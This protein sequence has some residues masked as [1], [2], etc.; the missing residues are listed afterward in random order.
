VTPSDLGRLDLGRLQ[1]TDL[2]GSQGPIMGAIPG[3][4]A[5][6]EAPAQ[7]ELRPTC[8]G[9]SLPGGATLS[10]L[11]RMI[12]RA[13]SRPT[14]AVR[15]AQSWGDTV[16]R[17]NP[18]SPGSGGASSYLRRGDTPLKIDEQARRPEALLVQSGFGGQ[19]ITGKLATLPSPST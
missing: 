2:G 8:P 4:E 7:A 3:G 19:D 14:F 17:G 6:R 13:C 9:D 5:T 12:W 11:G 16:R 15:K 1:Q 10:N 18:G